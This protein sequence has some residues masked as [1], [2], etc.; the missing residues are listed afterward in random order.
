MYNLPTTTFDPTCTDKSIKGIATIGDSG[1]AFCS[2]EDGTVLGITTGVLPAQ[3]ERAT[4]F[5]TVCGR[6]TPTTV[7]WIED[8]F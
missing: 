6:M 7:R 5:A 2:Q 8:N 3:G 1:A 4:E